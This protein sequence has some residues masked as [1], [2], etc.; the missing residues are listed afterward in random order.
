VPDLQLLGS[1]AGDRGEALP[2]DGDGDAERRRDPAAA[3]SV[4]NATAPRRSTS[5]TDPSRVPAAI[6][7]PATASEVSIEGK[8]RAHAGSPPSSSSRRPVQSVFT[9]NRRSPPG[10]SRG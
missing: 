10:L 7:S 1:D 6:Q 3:R 9:R 8:S 2:V 5:A 4:G